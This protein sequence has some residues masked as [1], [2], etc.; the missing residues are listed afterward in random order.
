MSRTKH[1]LNLL[2]YID[3]IV[4]LST[5]AT[6]CDN[7]S[8]KKYRIGFSQSSSK[9]L[10]KQTMLQDMYRNV[11]LYDNF[12]LVIKDAKDNSQIQIE[13]INELLDEGV[14]LL[15]IS[16]NESDPITPAA[17]KAYK[18]GIPTIIVDRKINSDDYSVYVGGNNYSIGYDAGQ[19]LAQITHGVGSIL[20]VLG[21]ASSSILIERHKGFSDAIKPYKNLKI[22]ATIDGNWLEETAYK[23]T[24]QVDS[25]EKI[26]IVFAH[27]DLMASGSRKA[28]K[29]K[30]GSMIFIGIN[31]LPG[32]N[33]GIQMVI[34]GKL[35]A[36]LLYPTGGKEA[37]DVAI[38]ILN[39]ES[40]SKNIILTSALIDSTNA[41]IIQHQNDITTSYMD[42][43][44]KQQERLQL[45]S[46]KYYTL[47]LLISIL[48]TALILLIVFIFLT[49]WA[50]RKKNEMNNMLNETIKILH[51]NK[52]FIEKQSEELK[53][54]KEELSKLNATKDKLF[55]ILAH[56]LRNPFNVIIG[57]SDLLLKEFISL[58]KDEVFN[59]ISLIHSS[60]TKTNDLLDN[61]LNWSQSQAS[62]V[63][64]NPKLLNLHNVVEETKGLLEGELFRKSIN[65]KNVTDPNVMVKSDLNMLKVILRNL[66]TNAIKFSYK[67]GL[68][69]IQ[70]VKITKSHLTQIS[71]TDT[72]IG[73]TNERINNLFQI[74]DNI[75]TSGTENE[76]GTGLGLILCKEFVE[77]HSGRIWVE[78]KLNEGTTFYFTLPSS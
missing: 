54:Q 27:S 8:K 73:I 4:I 42:D 68:I 69:T 70:S 23:N 35:T 47:R 74:N 30:A 43:I 62:R 1:I 49:I 12:Q 63:A 17:V 51:E 24:K 48:T 37:I 67:N 75:S 3:L 16:P 57:F 29:E 40:Y 66:I 77:K 45:L 32:K 10:W 19:Y 20:E 25:I 22:V 64:F 55:S 2:I 58:D 50:Y 7:V 15:I 26:S 11:L 76:P 36:S 21:S 31:A 61:L 14:D 44:D 13:Q 39:N 9:G 41:K 28:F 52:L 33:G 56:D 46:A 71:I 5:F 18:K 6:S 60:S 38:K 72:G 59:M 78:S 53:L 34:D 65:F